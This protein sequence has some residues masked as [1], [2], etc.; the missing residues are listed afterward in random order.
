MRIAPCAIEA[1]RQ[2]DR[3]AGDVD[4]FMLRRG[5][6]GLAGQ[7]QRDLLPGLHAVVV[8][9]LRKLGDGEMAVL[10]DD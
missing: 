1:S 7:P 10:V 3:L 5:D 8:G 2:H 6:A 4:Q 9:L